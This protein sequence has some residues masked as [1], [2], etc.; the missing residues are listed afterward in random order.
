M[1]LSGD[2]VDRLHCLLLTQNIGE[3]NG[4]L[5]CL[6]RLMGSVEM[7]PE[8]RDG[9][10]G[11]VLRVKIAAQSEAFIPTR[12]PEELAGKKAEIAGELLDQAIKTLPLYGSQLLQNVK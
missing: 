9:L 1:H 10:E 5:I 2:D 12:D 7:R 11:T 4:G 3:L 8:M 6:T